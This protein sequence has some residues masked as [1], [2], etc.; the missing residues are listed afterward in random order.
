MRESMAQRTPFSAS[1]AVGEYPEQH[2]L[3]AAAAYREPAADKGPVGKQ[4]VDWQ[5]AVNRTGVRCACRNCGWKA[6]DQ[7][8]F[9][10]IPVSVAK[11]GPVCAPR[12]F[13]N[14]REIYHCD[15]ASGG[16]TA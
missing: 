11:V 14:G 5:R 3:P 4:V 10:E 7:Q 12:D 16:E 8:T 1:R 2:Y 9:V 13:G 6:T 15:F